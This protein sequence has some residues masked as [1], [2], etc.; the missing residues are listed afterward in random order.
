MTNSTSPPITSST[1]N[2]SSM[3]PTSFSNY[4]DSAAAAAAVA[5]AAYYP[6]LPPSSTTNR[7]IQP[8]SA[9]VQSYGVHQTNPYSGYSDAAAYHLLSRP[10][11]AYPYAMASVNSKEMA[12]PAM[13]YIALI[14]SA[15]QNSPDQKCTLNGI[16]QYIMDQYPVSL[17]FFLQKKKL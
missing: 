8:P 12:K 2:N 11:A 9:S 17:Y 6:T 13:S 1:N 16:Y 10:S 15:I 7:L 3:P 14:T 4:Y 5:A